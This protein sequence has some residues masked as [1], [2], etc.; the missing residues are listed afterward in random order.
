MLSTNFN[1][2]MESKQIIEALRSGVP[3]KKVGQYFSEARPNTL[4]K[5]DNDLTKVCETGNSKGIVFSGKYGE[6]K[7]H[8]LNT[9]FNMA[10]EKNMVVSLLPLGKETP[11]DKLYVIYQKLIQN[12][13]LPGRLQPGIGKVYE[14][15]TENSPVVANLSMYA[16]KQLDTDKLFYLLGAYVGTEEQDE[17]YA[18]ECDL[19]GDFIPNGNLK[20]I[21]KRI[22]K[23]TVKYNTNF[24]KTKHCMDYIFFMSQLFK[25]MGYEGWAI[26]FDETEL[27]GRM[28]KKARL[29]SYASMANFLLPDERLSSVYTMFALSASYQ[30]DVIDGKHEYE[31]LAEVFPDEMEPAKTVLNLMKSCEQLRP[32]SQSET[33]QILQQIMEFHGVAYEWDVKLDFDELKRVSNRGGYLLRTK[34]RAAIEYLDQL[35]QYGNGED[36]EVSELGQLSYDEYEEE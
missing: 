27:M 8:L 7:T 24:S 15:L 21:Y 25:A 4:N 30:E 9:V 18:L 26:L 20:K 2:S 13:Y 17:K 32:L 11:M 36:A 1:S 5:I 3:S 28:S 34:I 19:E 12:T 35:Y 33:D 14:K 23:Q 16:G 10:H 22:T 6:G 31:N 29:K